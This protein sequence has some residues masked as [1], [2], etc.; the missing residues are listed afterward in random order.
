MPAAFRFPFSWRGSA[1][2]ENYFA[3][4]NFSTLN[5]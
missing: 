5:F 2:I 1:K 3:I 4:L